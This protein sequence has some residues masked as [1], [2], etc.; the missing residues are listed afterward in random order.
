MKQLKVLTGICLVTTAL[1]ICF[2]R[3]DI[4]GVVQ[5]N[6]KDGQEERVYQIKTY[7]QQGHQQYDQRHTESTTDKGQPLSTL[8][9]DLQNTKVHHLD[10]GQIFDSYNMMS[11]NVFTKCSLNSSWTLDQS[12]CKD[13][14]VFKSVKMR[15]K[16]GLVDIY[17]HDPRKDTWVSATL[18]RS[19]TWEQNTTEL[20]SSVLRAER[21]AVL[22]DIGANIG[23]Y[24]LTAAK[25]GFKV[26]AVEPLKINVQRIC[27][28][29][30]AGNFTEN[31]TVVR[32]ALSNVLQKVNLG[33]VINNIGGSYVLQGKN[34]NKAKSTLVRGKY[35]DVIWTTRLDDIMQLPAFD[36]GKVIIKMDVEGYE[37][38][39]LSGGVHFF[40]RM[41][42]P[43]VL[44]E[45]TYHR[46]AM[47]GKEILTFFENRNYIAYAPVKNIQL[48]LKRSYE[49]PADILW[50][51][52][53]TP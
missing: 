31:V 6:H 15:T 20:I 13:V 25:L 11:V 5:L 28:S 49:W 40:D 14:P 32:S 21:D 22:L 24:T 2:N 46:K 35:P 27:K 36:S 48:D 9:P 18:S 53:K 42:V 38:K 3:L 33:I 43:T 10:K 4:H 17:I 7:N 8:H 39:V 26:I 12:I 23:V 41:D 51:K 30:R 37:N 50:K 52:R 16:A 47:S 1:V 34:I 44:M 29:L 45:W 19:G